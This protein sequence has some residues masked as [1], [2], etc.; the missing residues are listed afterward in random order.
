MANIEEPRPQDRGWYRSP[1]LL[2]ITV[3]AL[4]AIISLF[5]I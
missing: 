5:F 3:L 4:T 1:L 2:G